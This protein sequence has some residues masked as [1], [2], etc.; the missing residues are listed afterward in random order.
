MR[1]FGRRFLRLLSHLVVRRTVIAAALITLILFIALAATAG[2]TEFRRIAER[3]GTFAR[4][5]H[6]SPSDPKQKHGPN[7]PN[8]TN[9]IQAKSA[10]PTPAPPLPAPRQDSGQQAGAP[11]P[12]GST[13]AA[14][15]FAGDAE[16]SFWHQ[17][18]EYFFVPG[19]S[20]PQAKAG[21]EANGGR[22]VRIDSLDLNQRLFRA[23]GDAL[24]IGL[25]D[26]GMAG[27]WTWLDGQSPG[28]TNWAPGQPDGIEPGL[29]A[30]QVYAQFWKGGMGAWD[31]H[32]PEGDKVMRGGIAERLS[33]QPWDNRA[34]PLAIEMIPGDW[35]GSDLENIR[36]VALSAANQIWKNI[37]GHKLAKIKIHRASGAP[38]L[39]F[40]RGPQGENLVE[41]NSGSN[42]WAQIAYQFAHEFYH[43]L[44][45]P[46]RA[47]AFWF[48]EVLGEAASMFCLRGMAKEWAT[49]P[50]YPNWKDYARSL[51]D[52]AHNLLEEGRTIL[53]SASL[54]DFI[55]AN[56]MDLESCNREKMK[57]LAAALL[58]VF[59]SNPSGWESVLYGDWAVRPGEGLETFLRRWKEACPARLQ[60]FVTQIASALGQNSP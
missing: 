31:N 48:S 2:Q 40:A 6:A 17:G 10:A 51:E 19:R 21:A 29:H 30:G 8:P 11:T 33:G 18:K 16:V 47:G 27:R 28:F 41:I 34:Y 50:P 15:K 46:P 52:Y 56:Q 13:G 54:H 36:Q 53:G 9:R 12:G 4:S 58:P 39:I 57:P 14:T 23:F 35:G 20:W 38:Q 59:E 37:R 26:E 44:A 25:Q 24:W 60:P 49:Q 5:L 43:V 45:A 1:S 42:L 7:K 22:L 55:A 3:L 32:W